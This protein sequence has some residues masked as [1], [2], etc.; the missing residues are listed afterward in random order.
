MSGRRNFSEL[1]AA[2]T[3]AQ[4]DNT[5]GKAAA[6]REEMNLADLRRARS[7]TQESLGEALKVGQASIAKMEKRADM[8]VS[9]LRRFV[10]A[11]GGELEV[12]ARFPEGRVTIGNFAEIE[13]PADQG[14]A[15]HPRR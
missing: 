7:L 3:P 14:A 6:L 1:R 13:L 12:V 4:R 11:M 9:S 5:A 15:P 8:Y 2:M 10:E